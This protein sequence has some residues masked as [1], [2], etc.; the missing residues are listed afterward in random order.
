MGDHNCGCFNIH[1]QI[2]MCVG[3]SAGVWVFSVGVVI[4]AVVYPSG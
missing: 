3:S 2:D 1:M 4:D